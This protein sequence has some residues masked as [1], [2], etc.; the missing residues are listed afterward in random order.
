MKILQKK[1]VITRWAGL[2]KFFNEKPFASFC[3][4]RHEIPIH[5]IAVKN[6]RV[7]FCLTQQPSSETELSSY[8]SS[9]LAGAF[10]FQPQFLFTQGLDFSAQDGPKIRAGFRAWFGT[11]KLKKPS[12]FGAP[13]WPAAPPWAR[14]PE[15][16]CD[17]DALPSDAATSAP[18]SEPKLNFRNLP[19]QNW[20]K[21][22]EINL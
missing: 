4:T 22:S 11:R 17:R 21:F 9:S 8:L 10:A 13:P 19:S 12:L 18:A 5:I 15:P 14:P 20:N 3:N 6:F 1:K 7:R 16:G 2:R